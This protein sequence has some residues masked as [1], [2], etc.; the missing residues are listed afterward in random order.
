ML[1]SDFS[2][3]PFAV[4]RCWDPVNN[5]NQEIRIM[6][7]ETLEEVDPDVTRNWYYD[8]K[9]TWIKIK[10]SVVLKHVYNYHNPHMRLTSWCVKTKQPV[11]ATCFAI[12]DEKIPENY[13]DFSVPSNVLVMF[14][15]TELKL[16]LFE[17][18]SGKILSGFPIISYP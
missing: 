1:T 5:G 16:Y 6:N 2:L 9:D 4:D 17:L 8:Y 13:L 7:N 14:S 11:C 10:D 3:C 18:N 15:K 12:R